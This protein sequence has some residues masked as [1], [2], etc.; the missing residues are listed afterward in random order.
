MKSKLIAKV[1][2]KPSKNVKNYI[3]KYD[4]NSIL[5]ETLFLS[6]VSECNFDKLLCKKFGKYLWL[7]VAHTSF[8]TISV[9]NDIVNNEELKGF[10]T[11]T[12]K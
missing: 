9:L 10:A 7:R 1:I 6:D 5:M 3:Y 11:V 12:T 4:D 8:D 2:F